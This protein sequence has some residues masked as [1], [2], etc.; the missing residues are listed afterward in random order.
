MAKSTREKIPD[1]V[2][3]ARMWIAESFFQDMQL[4]TFKRALSPKPKNFTE[5]HFSREFLVPPE[6]VPVYRDNF[7]RAEP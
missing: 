4:F 6:K 7:G 5:S 3:C 1:G 2:A